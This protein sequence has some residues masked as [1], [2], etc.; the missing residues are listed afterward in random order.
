MSSL[1]NQVIND[2]AD[3]KGDDENESESEWCNRFI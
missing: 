2:E 1:I 3:R